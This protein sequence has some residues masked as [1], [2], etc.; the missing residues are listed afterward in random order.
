[1]EVKECRCELKAIQSGVMTS[2]P[3]IIAALLLQNYA[4]AKFYA[5]RVRLQDMVKMASYT[6]HSPKISKG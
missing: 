6:M 4:A 2:L 5:I 3:Q 1:M